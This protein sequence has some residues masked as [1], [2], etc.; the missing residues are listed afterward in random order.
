MMRVVFFSRLRLSKI[1]PL[2]AVRFQMP[3]SLPQKPA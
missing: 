3:R 1:M 2:K